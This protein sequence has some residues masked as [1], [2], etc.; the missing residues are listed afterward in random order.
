M[1]RTGIVPVYWTIRTEHR[2]NLRVSA[3]KL[4][5]QVYGMMARF[6]LTKAIPVYFRDDQ[7][8]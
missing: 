8:M 3:G 7:R 1:G 6:F 4:I 2:M 5:T